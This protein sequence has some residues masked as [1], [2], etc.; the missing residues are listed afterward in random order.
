[1]LK[2][3]VKIVMNGAKMLIIEVCFVI[4]AD[5]RKDSGI[6]KKHHKLHFGNSSKLG[7]QH[8]KQAFL[9]FFHSNLGYVE[10]M[11]Y[12]RIL[13]SLLKTQIKDI[14]VNI[15]ERFYRGIQSVEHLL[16][17]QRVRHILFR[18]RIIV[19]HISVVHML[20]AHYLKSTVMYA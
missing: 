8:I 17:Y 6:Q 4:S 13:Q 15:R 5:I 16:T 9:A 10:Q 20:V 14:T 1:M 19:A 11:G 2:D 18:S 3:Q 7:T 12:L